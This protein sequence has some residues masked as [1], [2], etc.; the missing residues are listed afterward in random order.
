MTQL[1]EIANANWQYRLGDDG[2]VS[3]VDDINQAIYTILRTPKG[4]VPHR[5]DFG[6]EIHLFIDQP[7]DVATP[8]LVRETFEA[9]LQWEP[10]V[11]IKTVNVQIIGA[12]VALSIHWELA[13]GVAATSVVPIL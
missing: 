4:S 3:G 10:R 5:P 12:A 9:V 11:K 7:V 13:D 2:V 6:S 1:S 8:S